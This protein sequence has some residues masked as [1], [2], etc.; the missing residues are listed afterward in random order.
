MQDNFRKYANELG[1]ILV[2]ESIKD[3]FDGGAKNIEKFSSILMML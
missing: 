2:D 1:W 3:S